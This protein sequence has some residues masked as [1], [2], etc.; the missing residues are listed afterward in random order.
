[1]ARAWVA[2]LAVCAVLF[3]GAALYVVDSA[4]CIGCRQCVAVCPVG[5]IQ[6]V[7]GKAVI[8]PQKCIGCGKCALVCPTKAISKVAPAGTTAVE[9]R[10]TTATATVADSAETLS[11][12]T[13]AVRRAFVDTSRCVG[14]KLCLRACPV[15]AI[16]I[17]KGK[18]VIDPEKCIGCGKCV[19]VCPVKAI[20]WVGDEGG[21]GDIEQGQVR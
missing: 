8:D 5:A 9:V 11:V 2:T 13:L 18:A 16:E 7:G 21:G 3:A 6:V 4:R 14:C 15:G 20:S 17:I 10:E 1:M 12:D 19:S